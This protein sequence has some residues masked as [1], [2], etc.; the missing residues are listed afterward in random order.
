MR[1]RIFLILSMMLFSILVAGCDGGAKTVQD[2]KKKKSPAVKNFKEKPVETTSNDVKEESRHKASSRLSEEQRRIIYNAIVLVED[3]ALQEAETAF[4][5]YSGPN[6]ST[7]NIR[8]NVKFSKQLT[9]KYLAEV[10]TKYRIS[11]DEQTEIGN[12]GLTKEWP[13]PEPSMP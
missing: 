9:A 4:P 10:R 7:D 11:E 3:R 13:L 8:P 2:D 1:K 5:T 12:E 6:P